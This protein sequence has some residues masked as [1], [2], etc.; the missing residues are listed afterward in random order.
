[1]KVKVSLFAGAAR[2]VGKDVCFKDHDL[3]RM[4]ENFD[5]PEEIISV[6][7]YAGAGTV[8]NGFENKPGKRFARAGAY[9]A[10]GVG[11]ARYE[12]SIV[13]AEIKGP[14]AAAG[15]GASS[16]SGARAFVKAEVASASVSVGPAK[17]TVGLAADTGVSVGSSGVEARML[18]T[19]FAIGPARVSIS[20]LGSSIEFS[21]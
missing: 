17:A 11:Y 4:I 7:T 9:A 6:G 2:R 10:A 18:G 16:G 19:G 14:N 5:R 8:A 15:I 1:M 12:N 20:V 3:V 13:D 21:L